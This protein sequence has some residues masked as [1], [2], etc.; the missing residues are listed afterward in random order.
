MSISVAHDQIT[1]EEQ[2]PWG[3]QIV[4]R[5]DKNGYTREPDWDVRGGLQPGPR[6]T[7]ARCFAEAL[8]RETLKTMEQ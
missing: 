4:W 1:I 6:P 2:D 8:L 3:R 7:T 5:H